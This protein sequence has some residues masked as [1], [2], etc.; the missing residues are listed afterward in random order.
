MQMQRASGLLAHPT[1]F[2]SKYGIGDLGKGASDFVDFLESAKQMLWQILPLG[3]TGFGD[4]PYQS[5]ST[6]AGNHF[7]ISP[8]ILCEE[9][10]LTFSD[11]EAAPDFDPKSVDYGPVID[12]KVSLL[13]KAFKKFKEAAKPEQLNAYEKFCKKEKGWLD[14]YTLFVALKKHFIEER[15][16]DLGSPA[17]VAYTEANKKHLSEDQIKDYYYG[18]VWSSWPNDI[19]KREKAALSTYKA[20]LAEDIEFHS[21]LQYEF[22]RQWNLIKTYANKKGIK[23]IGDIPI[24]VA[25]DS[26]DV[27]ADVSLFRLDSDGNPLAVA[28]VPPDYFSETGQLWGNPLYEWAA[29]KKQSY[30]WWISRIASTLKMVDIVRIDHFR[31]FESYWAI[32]YGEETAVKGKWVKGPGKPLFTALTKELGEL[33]IIAEDLGIITDKVRALRESLGFPGMRVLQFSF[34]PDAKNLY[35]P[36]NFETADTVLYTGTHDND[37]SVGWYKSA[38]EEEKDYY[39]RYLNVSGEEVA[40][41]LIRLAWASCANYAIAPIQDIF[42]LDENSRMNVP[43]EP[44]GNWR[45]RY[46]EDMLNPDIAERLVYLSEMFNRANETKAKKEDL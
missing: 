26:S 31:G 18:A 39:R 34:S 21:F 44:V 10:Y 35:I 25:L 38:L 15:K 1:S 17:L 28:G 20:Q 36:H 24:F 7:L 27:W 13:W 41:D 45:F 2:P 40:W 4:S 11:I 32:P 12:Y 22:F 37:T 33:P 8:D 19:A 30:S 6:F 9:G 23:I 14:N 43:G 16:N 46:T 29:H 3:P 42:S 5:F